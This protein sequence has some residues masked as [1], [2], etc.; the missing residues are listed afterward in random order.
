MAKGRSQWLTL[1][2]G[3]S[4]LVL[5][6]AASSWQNW[7]E[8]KCQLFWLAVQ[9]DGNGQQYCSKVPVCSIGQQY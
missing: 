5:R 4:G 6:L 2:T 3:K 8:T 1:L 9:I 7:Q